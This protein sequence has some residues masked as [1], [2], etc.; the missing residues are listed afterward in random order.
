MLSK[1]GETMAG[2][3][4]VLGHEQTIAHMKKAIELGK[5]SHAYIINGEKGSGKKLLAGIFAQT[6]QCEKKGTEPCMQ[7]QSCHQ[8]VSMN[9]PDIIR[10]TH[11]KPNTI[12]VEDIRGQLNGDIQIK[13]YSSPYKIYIVDEAEKLS[14][15]AQNALLKTIEEPP[16]YAVILFLTNTLDV[17][18]QTV[19]SRCIIMN[20]RSVDTKLIQQYL[21]QKYQLPDYQARVCAAYAQ[22]NVGKAIMMATSEHF[23]EMQDFL[24]R[25]LKRVDDMEVYEIVAA[26]HD[27]TTYKM[28]IRDLIDLMMV[29]YRDVLILKATE[30]I[31]QLVY[32]DEHKYLQKKATTSSYEGLNNIM[33]A[34]EKAKVRLNDNVN[35]EITME[36]LLLT[37]KEN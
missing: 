2:F 28:D 7:C 10:V 22:G 33:E 16:E 30:D 20:L 4:D 18:L 24:L 19:R 14:P 23:R 21:M 25:L 3:A 8:A 36:M 34:L 37:I 1:R 29:W 6:L 26:I 31:N 11:E 15:Q 35:F 32:Q 5:V 27:M 17:L 9:Q 13:P 12:S